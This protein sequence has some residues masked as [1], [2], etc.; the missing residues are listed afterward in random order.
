MSIPASDRPVA[1]VTG[2]SAGIG[3]ACVK[4]FAAAGWNVTA[5]ARR[6][7][8]LEALA[9]EVKTAQPGA[10]VATVV[11]DVDD[12][13]SVARAFEAHAQKFGRLDA[14][15]NN[16]GYG[17]YGTVEATPLERFRGNFETN[18]FGVLRCTKAALPL[19]RAAARSSDRRWG[20]AIVMVSSFVGKRAMP[21]MSAY[22]A[23]KHAL[24]GLGESLRIELSG[25]RISVSMINPGVTKTEFF[26]VA[27]GERPK[28]Y[29]TPASGMSAEAVAKI[30]LSAALRPRR[31]AYLTLPGKA[32]L[33][34][35]WISPRLLDWI[36]AGAWK[37]EQ[38]K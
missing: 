8:R 14:L 25:E 28:S 13:A 20:A 38:A 17:V 35:Q 37:K 1:F 6:L 26:N 9:R 12:D 2:A 34:A 32:G 16:A 22:C 10:E 3:A 33:L 4:V 31:N 19:L 30:I 21:G 24:E 27:E 18:F 29:L 5:A 15:I 23:S 7:D 36:M 11:C